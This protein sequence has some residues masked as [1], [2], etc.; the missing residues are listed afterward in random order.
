MNCFAQK[1]VLVRMRKH[2]RN[3]LYRSYSKP[4]MFA[5]PPKFTA[6]NERMRDLNKDRLNAIL[7]WGLRKSVRIEDMEIGESI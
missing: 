2:T 3:G 1:N 6:Q 4:F 7:T 5:Q